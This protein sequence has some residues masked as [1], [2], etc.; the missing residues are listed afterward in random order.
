MPLLDGL[1]PENSSS[2]LTPSATMT[3]LSF[4]RSAI[5]GPPL[6][7]SGAFAYFRSSSLAMARLWTSSGPSA[8]ASCASR[9]NRA[10]DPH[11]RKR[12]RT[13]RLN[14]LSMIFSA[15]NWAPH[16]DHGDLELRGLMPTLSIMSAA[17]ITGGGSSR[18]RCGLPQCAAPSSNISMIFLPNAVRDDSPHH[19]LERLFGLADG[20]HAVMDAAG[21]RRPCAISK[22]LPSA[23]QNVADGNTDVFKKHLR[24]AVRCIVETNTGQHLLTVM[25]WH[26]AH[27]DLRL[28]LMT[29]RLVSVLPITI[30]T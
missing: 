2:F 8:S 14:G 1:V 10:P 29:R 11:R 9:R 16:L 13:E 24:V 4:S 5:C 30:R 23:E 6:V 17:F 22:P 15:I 20:A 7:R 3:L 28:L 21:P 25:P 18:Y 19:F 27:Q 26:R 12:R